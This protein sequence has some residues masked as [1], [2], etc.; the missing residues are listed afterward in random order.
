M[1]LIDNLCCICLDDLN[2]V[3]QKKIYLQCC[4]NTLHIECFK[5]LIDNYCPLCRNKIQHI[6]RKNCI[7]YLLICIFFSL[8]L[9][10]IH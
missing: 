9:Y 5:M 8:F 1:E 4:G 10:F 2:D 3:T 7:K 6:Y